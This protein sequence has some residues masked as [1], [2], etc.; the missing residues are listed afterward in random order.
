MCQ[1]T[2]TLCTWLASHDTVWMAPW[3]TICRNINWPLKD[4][5]NLY[6]FGGCRKIAGL[7][8]S[9]SGRKHL[10]DIKTWPINVENLKSALSPTITASATPCTEEANLQEQ[11]FTSIISRCLIRPPKF[12]LISQGTVWTLHIFLDVDSLILVL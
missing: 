12:L 11:N 2:H 10:H 3:I 5:L 7:L 6:C 9:S 1:F 8:L 4:N